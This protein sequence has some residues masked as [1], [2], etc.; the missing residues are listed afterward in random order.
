MTL[1]RQRALL[2]CCGLLAALAGALPLD[3]WNLAL[4]AAVVYL[5]LAWPLPPPRTTAAVMLALCALGALRLALPGP[6]GGFRAI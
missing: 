3:P 2:L 6:T 4:A 5:A 1:S